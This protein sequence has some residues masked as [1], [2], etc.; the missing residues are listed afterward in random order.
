MTTQTTSTVKVSRTLRA[1]PERVFTAWLDPNRARQF[2]FTRPSQV[3]VRAEI[4]ARVGG[5][6]LFVARRDGKDFEH[7][8]EYLEID[9]PRRL[10]FTLCVPAVWTDYNRVTVEFKP[11]EDGCEITITHEGVLSN[12]LTSIN[13]GWAT[14]LETLEREKI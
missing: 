10:V 9:P 2:L 4:D 5:S 8:G 1:A 14:F 3:V 11:V 6:C 13:S 7:V 12:H